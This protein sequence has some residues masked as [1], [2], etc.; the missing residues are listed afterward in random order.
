MMKTNIEKQ[1]IAE[2]VE[3][4]EEKLASVREKANRETDEIK[5]RAYDTCI[6]YLQGSVDSLRILVNEDEL[7][8]A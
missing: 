3:F 1:N 7:Q 2:L 4:Y 8:I 5:I 6:S